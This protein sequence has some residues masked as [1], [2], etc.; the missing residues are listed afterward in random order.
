MEVPPIKY[1]T[2]F[3][4]S[5]LCIQIRYSA[6]ILYPIFIC[7]HTILY[8][9]VIFCIHSTHL[10]TVSLSSP[11]FCPII[12][13]FYILDA[14]SDR[15]LRSHPSKPSDFVELPTR[16]KRKAKS[17]APTTTTS[18]EPTSVTPPRTPTKK[19]DDQEVHDWIATLPE[20]RTFPPVGTASES[21]QSTPTLGS[22]VL[23]L[24]SPLKEQLSL[25]ATRL[26]NLVRKESE[27]PHAHSD[28][29][30]TLT[31]TPPSNFTANRTP[32]RSPSPTPNMPKTEEENNRE[33]SDVSSDEEYLADMEKHLG[34]HKTAQRDNEE[35]LG[36][37]G[38]GSHGATGITLLPFFLRNP[39]L[40]KYNSLEDRERKT[41]KRVTSALLK[42]HQCEADKEIAIQEISNCT[43]GKG[44]VRDFAE[45]IRKLGTYAY[46]DLD[47]A[48]RDRLMATHLLNGV[49]K[50]IRLELR[51]LPSTPK[52]LREMALQAEKI[53]RLQK[54]EADEDEEED[55]RIAAVQM[56][57]PENQQRGHFNF[58]G[59]GYHGGYYNQGY[60]QGRR[61]WQPAQQ[62]PPQFLPQEQWQQFQQFQQWQ[63]QQQQGFQG[64]QPTQRPAIVAP[65]PPP[66]ARQ[67]SG[68]THRERL[69]I[70]SVSKF[71]L[72]ICAISLLPMSSTLQICGFGL[73]GN[74]FVPPSPISCSFPS[75]LQLQRHQIHIHMP[76][77]EAVELEAF[78]CFK[79][80]LKA[81]KFGFLSIY[82]VTE[83]E[84]MKDTYVDVSVD[85]CRNAI[86]GKKYQNQNLEKISP[87]YYRTDS[88]ANWTSTSYWFGSTEVDLFE[89]TVQKGI[90]AT[91]DGSTIVSD[92]VVWE[93]HSEKRECPY[94]YSSTT[95]AI[96][97]Y[98]YIAVEELDIFSKIDKDLRKLHKIMDAC[99]LNNALLTDDGILIE[100][101]DQYHRRPQHTALWYRSKREVAYIMGEDG[102]QIALEIGQNFTTPL[103]WKLF[104]KTNIMDGPTIKQNIEDP[105]LLKEFKRFNVTKTILER[106][107]RFYP[108]DRKHPKNYLIMALKA[109]RIAQ[110]TWRE[111]K[112]L[113]ELPRELSPG[114]RT[115]KMLLEEGDT[116]LFDTLLAREFGESRQDL[117]NE[118]HEF[119]LPT[120]NETQMAKEPRMEPYTESSWIAPPPPAAP[121][122]KTTSAPQ[123]I[124]AES[125][126]STQDG[127][128]S[129]C[130]NQYMATSLFETLLAI[131]PTA[132][133][134]QLLKRRDVSAKRV[135]DSLLVSKCRPVIPTTTHW[136]RKI[137]NTCYEL[138]PVTVDDVIWFQLPG[139]EDLVG[140]A[141]T[142]PCIE[143]T[144]IIHQEKLGGSD[145]KIT[146]YLLETPRTFYTTLEEETGVSTGADKENERRYS[147]HQRDLENI[148]QKDGILHEGW[149]L[150][151]NTTRQLG[152]SAKEM[153]HST[154][155]S[156]ESGS[157][158]IFFSLVDLLL[159]I[160]IPLVGMLLCIGCTY[161]YV[162]YLAFKKSTK[163]ARR[164]VSSTTDALLGQ[165][166]HINQVQVQANAPQPQVKP[167]IHRTY[168]QEYPV[169]G[170][171]AVHIKHE[172]TSQTPHIDVF[173]QEG[174]LEALF[175]TGANVTY[176]RMGCVKGKIDTT[177]QSIARA[178]NG[179]YIQFLGTITEE[180]SIG[181]IHIPHEIRV[182][183]D[184]DCPADMLIGTDVMKKINQTGLTRECRRLPTAH[185]STTAACR[186]VHAKG[187]DKN[188]GRHEHFD[189]L[190]LELFAICA[191]NS[192]SLTLRHSLVSIAINMHKKEIT[193]GSSVISINAITGQEE[194]LEVYPTMDVDIN[195]Q[196]EAVI[197]ATINNL[198]T[199]TGSE[200]LLED[201]RQD[202]GSDIYSVA[203]SMVTAEKDGKTMVQVFNPTASTLRVKTKKPIAIAS[204]VSEI[205]SLD[206]DMPPPEAHWESKLPDFPQ[207]IPDNFRISDM[208]DLSEANLTQEEKQ[209][210]IEIIDRHPKAFVGKDGVLGEYTGKIKHRIDLMNG[211]KF[212]Q[213][214]IYRIPLE[215]REEIE[216]KSK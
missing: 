102:T 10:S 121:M 206:Q 46:D 78:K 39:A 189:E 167:K 212:P 123:N 198:D 147:R 53:E 72:L 22:Q 73:T 75:E 215:K 113:A 31:G 187:G 54:I 188:G 12:E 128:M 177:K 130:R 83:M 8:S 97:N 129:S 163:L 144:P 92:L 207:E 101:P 42:L 180:I 85:E 151:R 155:D 190:V 168:E 26:H 4:Y 205:K 90:I 179:G 29:S 38:R 204:R 201:T 156:I 131:D 99:F 174:V 28:V 160:C 115:T 142:I 114:E 33:N 203:K 110:Y 200:F 49:S 199:R 210:L 64:F 76:R 132:A 14:S 55:A 86:L 11:S 143:R 181:D 116:F 209:Q 159:W 162:K 6:D 43:Q 93:T 141:A 112:R 94:Q 173:L 2:F 196:S 34:D 7:I 74:L 146:Q 32:T 1:R 185:H 98:D 50:D 68:Q 154:I 25:L 52:T 96:V 63:Q 77:P 18:E 15:I 62:Y 58:R 24:N 66:P 81:K 191:E 148:L 21:F 23:T 125:T 44:S 19:S 16:P 61:R 118:D 41:W 137:N 127:F 161:G 194:K 166:L 103:I 124:Q 214:K 79:T 122:T 35:V 138:V 45:K 126:I 100:F 88:M 57:F 80:K 69:G 51:R 197:P 208:V 153:Y 216:I 9:F 17:K 192:Q 111:K 186:T 134:R 136:S 119:P 165:L 140:E 172:K 178:A 150:L 48:A 67:G 182:S 117:L 30:Q 107:G 108:E 82:Q 89:F 56:Q 91:M 95:N 105:I 59:R 164:A 149:D 139:S 60:N 145:R 71:L 152:K 70:N 65:P 175:D 176:M 36:R 3:I 47:K 87:G 158:K 157:R 5:L 135:G 183:L 211:C 20:H 184:N 84:V 106:C 120:F 193:I 195:P 202:S 13:T 109:I 171:N 133:V 27:T 37:I 213:A 104:G 169:V 170:V 40:D